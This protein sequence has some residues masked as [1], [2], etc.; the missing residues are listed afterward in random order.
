MIEKKI[1]FPQKT[2]DIIENVL[3]SP[4]ATG[5]YRGEEV[6]ETLNNTIKSLD[7]HE[8]LVIDICKAFPLE[9]SFCEYAFGPLL[10]KLNENK[11][12]NKLIIFHLLKDDEFCF[13][14]GVLKHID[15]SIPRH[16]SISSA[17]SAFIESG[18]FLMMKYDNNNE[19]Q[20]IAKLL[21]IEQEIL[22]FV[23][24]KE[25]VSGRGIIEAKKEFES[26]TIVDSI[27]SLKQ[28]GFIV[29]L[30][31]GDDQYYSIY[32]YFKDR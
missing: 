2:I 19:I 30:E 16:G 26:E 23:N 28:K 31:D 14:R 27:R 7:T 11:A 10:K 12:E 15:S 17:K 29:Q 20:Y 32:K 5:S 4:M 22:T 13:F 18:M 1:P 24:E 25:A 3:Q 6:S 21:K 8:L 9:Y